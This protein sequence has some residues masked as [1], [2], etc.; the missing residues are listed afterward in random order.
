MRLLVLL[1]ISMTAFGAEKYNG[2]RPPKPDVPYLLHANKLVETEIAEAKDQQSKDAMTYS[3]SGANS[4]AKTPMA[5]PIF[6]LESDKLN[7]NAIEL[8]KLEVKGGNRQVTMPMGKKARSG[9]R[10]LKLT[11]QKVEGKLYRIEA[12]E[13]LEIGQYSLS[14]SDSNKA[15]CFE[16]F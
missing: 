3:I 5:E 4:P 12:A 9:P 16:V 7:P 6:L 13:G 10:P 2:P 11:V 15:F 1:A 8:Y 14:P